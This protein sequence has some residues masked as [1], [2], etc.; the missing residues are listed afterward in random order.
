MGMCEACR[1]IQSG[2][3]DDE[4][5][6]PECELYVPSPEAPAAIA[7]PT[8]NCGGP[9]MGTDHSPDCDVVL[10]YEDQRASNDVEA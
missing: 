10:Y 8:C 9:E 5:K 4:C 2:P 7:G 6:N 1:G 3:N